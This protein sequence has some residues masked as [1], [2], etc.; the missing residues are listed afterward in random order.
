MKHKKNIAR[1]YVVQYLMGSDDIFRIRLVFPTGR[2][3][4]IGYHTE[5]TGWNI[6][7]F[8]KNN[9]FDYIGEKAKSTRQALSLM[10]QYDKIWHFKSTFI[11]TVEL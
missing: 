9:I 6:S 5:I 1:L 10:K 2:V 3:E 11:G 7:C 8:V 4:Y